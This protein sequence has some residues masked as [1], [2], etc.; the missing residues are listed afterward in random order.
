MSLIGNILW[1]VFGGFLTGM[2]Y[3]LGGFLLCLTIIGIPFG[4][5]SIRIGM[6]NFAPFGKEI[7]PANR[8]GGT[9]GLVFDIIWVVLLGWE[10]A[11]AHLSSAGILA[12]TIIG[13]PFAWQ[14]L[15]LIPV[16]LFPF[17][18]ELMSTDSCSVEN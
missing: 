13:I 3:I 16:A 18:Y 5:Q 8:T 1:L 2:M 4:M 11:V 9:L 15:K 6:A 12:I 10:I 7:T 14:H 17:N